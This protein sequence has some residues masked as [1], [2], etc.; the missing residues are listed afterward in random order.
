ML[1][2]L[3]GVGGVGGRDLDLDEI[4][5]EGGDDCERDRGRYGVGEEF[6]SCLRVEERSE[7]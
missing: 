4:G 7:D 5:D 1:C 2:R 3:L 6:R